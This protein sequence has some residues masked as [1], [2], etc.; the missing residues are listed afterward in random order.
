MLQALPDARFTLAGG[1]PENPRAEA[2]WR[3]R[4]QQAAPA[5]QRGRVV[6]TGWLDQKDMMERYRHAD[7]LVSPSWFETFGQVVLEAML[8]GLPV[9]ATRCGGVAELLQ[10]G[11]LGLLSEPRD[12]DGL[13]ANGVRLLADPELAARLGAAAARHARE[14]YL[15]PLILPRLQLLY[16][17]FVRRRP[18]R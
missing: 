6:F 15:W 8:T 1:L 2:R 7:V 16:E 13:S 14:H 4:W 9:A 12:V 17:P 3:R 10:D 11:Q 18:A 5:S